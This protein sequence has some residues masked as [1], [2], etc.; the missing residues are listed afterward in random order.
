MWFPFCRP[1]RPAAIKHIG[2][3]LQPSGIVLHGAMWDAT[4]MGMFSAAAAPGG[5]FTPALRLAAAF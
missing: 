5:R 2:F 1:V 4:G 3:A